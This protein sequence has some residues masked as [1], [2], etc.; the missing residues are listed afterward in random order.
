M[1]KAGAKVRILY[2]AYKDLVGVIIV[3]RDKT[4]PLYDKYTVEFPNGESHAFSEN[5]LEI[6][7]K[8][9]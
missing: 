4:G 1:I 3:R 7:E 2:G 8:E 5:A 6:I 9:Q